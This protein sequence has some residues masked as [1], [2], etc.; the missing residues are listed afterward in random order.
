MSVPRQQAARAIDALCVLV[1]RRQVV[2]AARFTLNRARLDL[3]N[4]PE[5]NGEYSLQ[6]WVLDAIP[7]PDPVTVFDVGA[8][9]GTWSG[10]L[11]SQA[12]R[13][14]HGS[15]LELHAFEPASYT[16][17]VLRERLPA[18]VRVNHLALSAT[19]GQTTLYIT[20]PGA[21]TNSLHQANGGH[22]GAQQTEIVTTTTVDEYI[23]QHGIH[24][25]DF[26][27]LDTEGHDYQVLLGAL[28]ALKAKKIA[29]VQFEYN[30]RWVYARH[31]L[32]D[33]FDLLT[34]LRYMVGKLTPRGIEFYPEWD[35][36]LESFVEGNY[37]ACT[38]E[39]A[40]RLPS[41]AWWKN[42]SA[43]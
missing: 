20:H 8:N 3:P 12:H 32:K 39:M 28:G 22:G 25:I 37:V 21:G 5:T 33:A 17:A 1:G 29:A 36:E 14:G 16:H 13:E 34:P 10:S 38:Q 4:G 40:R 30:H 27:K 35:P 2:R 26:M 6:R 24:H 41:V 9:V 42:S 43:R 15:R 23:T 19:G 7:A 18:S 11:L 31:F